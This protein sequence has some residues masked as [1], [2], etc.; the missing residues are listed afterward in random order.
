MV[1]VQWGASKQVT[2]SLRYTFVRRLP[3]TGSVHDLV[4][5]LDSL[6]GA[7]DRLRVGRGAARE[8]CAQEIPTKSLIST[9]ILVYEDQRE[10]YTLSTR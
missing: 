2:E 10:P 4:F 1:H 5:R 3:T 7:V 9:S 6:H 8:K